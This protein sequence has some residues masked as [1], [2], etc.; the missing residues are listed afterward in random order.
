MFK[1]YDDFQTLVVPDP[2]ADNPC[3]I[4]ARSLMSYMHRRSKSRMRGS[5]L[6]RQRNSTMKA[7]TS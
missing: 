3:D 4:Y 5:T 6:E 1:V 2:E 7:L